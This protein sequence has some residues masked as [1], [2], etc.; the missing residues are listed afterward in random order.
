[1]KDEQ[2]NSSNKIQWWIEYII[3]H[4]GFPLHR[5]SVEQSWFKT[6]DTDIV[7]LGLLIIISLYYTIILIC[8]MLK[9]IISRTGVKN[10]LL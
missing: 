8:T 5:S 9:K 4:K 2:C 7:L 1:M 3:R 10:K 6:V